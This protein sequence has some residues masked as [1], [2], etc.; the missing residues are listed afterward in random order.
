VVGDPRLRAD[1]SAA[2]GPRRG[3][4]GSSLSKYGRRLPTPLEQGDCPPASLPFDYDAPAFLSAAQRVGRHLHRSWI[5][6]ALGDVVL[7]T[8]DG[9]LVAHRV[10]LASASPSLD[11]L[12]R[13]K[14]ASGRRLFSALHTMCSSKRTCVVVKSS[15]TERSA[16]QN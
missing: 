8:A 5:D 11:T 2:S 7:Q 14:P 3:S 1:V 15:S 16:K 10:V 6:Q 13:K 4:G 9:E 12:F